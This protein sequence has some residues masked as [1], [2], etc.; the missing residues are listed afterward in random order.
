[1]IAWQAPRRPYQDILR[2]IKLVLYQS[3]SQACHLQQCFPSTGQWNVIIFGGGIFTNVQMARV[4][5]L[6]GALFDPDSYFQRLNKASRARDRVGSV[7]VYLVHSTNRNRIYL[8]RLPEIF[9]A[10]LEDGSIDYSR[11]LADNESYHHLGGGEL[12]KS[13]GVD[14]EGCMVLL[15]PDQHIAFL[16]GIDDVHGLEGCLRS[17]TCV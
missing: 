3:D 2:T 5:C 16:S 17:F 1:L 15:R 8:F 7:G 14:P 12:Y 10:C 11:V 6:A 4:N 9:R 13:F